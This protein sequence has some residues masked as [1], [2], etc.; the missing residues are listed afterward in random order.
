MDELSQAGAFVLAIIVMCVGLAAGVFGLAVGR[1]YRHNSRCCLIPLHRNIFLSAMEALHIVSYPSQM[2]QDKWVS[3]T[4]FPGV[5]TGFF[6]DVGS[7]GGVFLSNTVALERKGW[8]GICIDPFPSQMEGRTCK[9]LK[10]VVSGETGQHVTFHTAGILGGIAD[11]LNTHKT[12]AE[13]SQPVEFITVALGEIL[14]RENAP[15][16]IHFMSLDIEGAEFEA[17]RSIHFDKYTF[18]ALA[19][20]HNFEEPK[21]TNILRLLEG[22]GYKRSHIWSHDDFYVPAER[23]AAQ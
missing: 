6:L 8:T 23:T 15:R 2:G 4:V 19:I 7:A 1:R 12:E 16:F 13:Q 17:L 22:H 9:M 20:E 11:H 14:E 21:R 18:G 10:E 5:T 3:E